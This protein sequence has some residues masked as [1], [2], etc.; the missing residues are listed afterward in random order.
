MTH[1]LVLIIMMHN[2]ILL[3]VSNTNNTL[4]KY[5]DIK[6]KTT[7]ISTSTKEYII[8]TCICTFQCGFTS[9][10]SVTR[11]IIEMVEL[12]LSLYIIFMN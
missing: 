12:I 3:V 2:I 7:E 9:A 10:Q 1:I 4:I 11:V 6:L 5:I 8:I